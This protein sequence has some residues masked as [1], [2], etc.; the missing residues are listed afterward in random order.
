MMRSIGLL[1]LLLLVAINTHATPVTTSCE[2]DLDTTSDVSE[3]APATGKGR[4]SLSEICYVQFK[5][6]NVT[7]STFYKWT[8]FW[9][10]TTDKHM[11]AVSNWSQALNADVNTLTSE[12][13][14]RLPT[15]KELMMLVDYSSSFTDSNASDVFGDNWMIKQWLLR[16]A[17]S[18]LIS[19]GNAYLVSST[20]TFDD[21]GNEDATDDVNL[22][23]A[24]HINTGEVEAIDIATTSN[25][26]V[27]KMKMEEPM[28]ESYYVDRHTDSNCLQPKSSGSNVTVDDCSTIESKHK[29]LYETN[30]NYMRNYSGSCIRVNVNGYSQR[31]LVILSTCQN[32]TG[33]DERS[34]R[35]DRKV[36]SGGGYNFQSKQDADYFFYSATDDDVKMWNYGSDEDTFDNQ[37][38]WKLK[39]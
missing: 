14:W 22:F 35:W 15:I 23:M 33:D 30:T 11:S 7:S 9:N 38:I 36:F 26:Y 24:L 12:T 8:G 17:T 25:V 27:L 29:W 2:S 19:M 28:W 37:S 13:G 3:S 39:P 21:K 1:G 10:N 5:K 31:N 6:D 16:G 32:F 18:G 34:A 4:I 20:Y